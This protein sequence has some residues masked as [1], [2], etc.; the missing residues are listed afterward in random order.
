[1]DHLKRSGRGDPMQ[2]AADCTVKRVLEAICKHQG[3]FLKGAPKRDAVEKVV[4]AL[5]H[6]A[7][8]GA[9]AQTGQA[10]A[11]LAPPGVCSSVASSAG[12]LGDPPPSARPLAPVPSE[13]P[14]LPES[15]VERRDLMDTLKKRVLQRDADGGAKATTVTAPPKKSGNTT[16]TNGMGGVGACASM[17]PPCHSS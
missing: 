17:L 7:A 14:M 4:G 2:A 12:G 11:G 8:E 13:V 16:T 3:E 10:E 9:S 1:M 5:V 6:V 15:A